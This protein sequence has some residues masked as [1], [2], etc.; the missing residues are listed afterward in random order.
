M[1]YFKYCS[2]SCFIVIFLKLSLSLWDYPFYLW[3]FF[4]YIMSKSMAIKK[5]S[6]LDLVSLIIP[7]YKQ[8]NTIQKDLFRAK[9]VMDEA[10][11]NY[12]IILVVDGEIDNT[13]KNAKKISS[14]KI[15][16]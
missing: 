11:Y 1:H 14:S 2:F 15:K 16:V 5:K 12:E 3:S 8:E 13:F 6:S 9:K 10:G 7:A 4:C